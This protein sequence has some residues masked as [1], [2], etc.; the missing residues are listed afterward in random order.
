MTLEMPSDPFGTPG[1]VFV[2]LDPLQEAN[3]FDD[4]APLPDDPSPG[5]DFIMDFEPDLDSS[6]EDEVLKRV[7]GDEPTP[8]VEVNTSPPPARTPVTV[9]ALAPRMPTILEEDEKEEEDGDVTI[10][11]SEAQKAL[12]PPDKFA[13]PPSAPQVVGSADAS[14]GTWFD[15]LDTPR[16]RGK[17][18]FVFY[19]SGSVRSLIL[20]IISTLSQPNQHPSP[21]PFQTYSSLAYSPKMALT[22]NVLLAKSTFSFILR[23]PVKIRAP[24][25]TLSVLKS[26][27]GTRRHS[28]N[29]LHK[30]RSPH[31]HLRPGS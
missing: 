1:G 12:L 28:G 6:F 25:L 5:F 19:S 17:F 15:P 26:P 20:A 8:F 11:P 22:P 13:R 10:T 27:L 14:Q 18:R 30:N 23:W 3:P 21:R 29:L 16:P 2:F 4:P 7:R 24:T 9:S 31:P